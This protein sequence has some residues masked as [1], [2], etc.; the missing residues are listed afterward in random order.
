METLE[1]VKRNTRNDSIRIQTYHIPT[2]E[3]KEWNSVH[4]FRAYTQYKALGGWYL[5][6]LR[7]NKLIKV[8]DYFICKQSNNFNVEEILTEKINNMD[9]VIG[10]DDLKILQLIDKYNESRGI[11]NREKF[12][13]EI[14]EKNENSY[15]NAV[16]ILDENFSIKEIYTG[17]II[18]LAEREGMNY[19]NMKSLLFKHKM[20]KENFY[21]G[22][23]TKSYNGKNY[24]YLADY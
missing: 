21:K 18:D 10:K 1:K 19:N 24:C 9:Y 23:E 13:K 22:V 6:K 20:R 2:G 16:L 4:K 17:K 7:D 3:I 12:I 14:K 11:S 5:K 15:K 8:K